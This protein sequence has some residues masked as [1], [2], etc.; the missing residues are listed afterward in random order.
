MKTAS[1]R[2]GWFSDSGSAAIE[3]IFWL[4]AIQLPMLVFSLGLFAAQLQLARAETVLRESARATIK[5]LETDSLSLSQ[6]Q[7]QTVFASYVRELGFQAGLNLDQTQWS[8]N[9]IP[10]PNCEFLSFSF[11]AGVEPWQPRLNLVF[12]GPEANL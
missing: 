12:S 5:Q 9:C 4:T 6:P 8:A 7:I 2:I 11:K 1:H 10:M 3:T